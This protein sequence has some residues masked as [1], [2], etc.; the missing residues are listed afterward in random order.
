ME[1]KIRLAVRKH[2]ELERTLSSEAYTQSSD[3][4]ATTAETLLNQ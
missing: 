4:E 1:G 2:S 3:C